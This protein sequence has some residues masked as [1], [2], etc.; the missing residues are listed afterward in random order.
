MVCAN[1]ASVVLARGEE[2][3]REIAIRAALGA[4]RWPI[5]RLL[6]TESV[7]LSAAGGVLGVGLAHLAVA[8]LVG[9]G[10]TTV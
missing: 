1:V 5:A 9:P 8:S 6:L 7:L 2:R 4:G 10:W 3:T